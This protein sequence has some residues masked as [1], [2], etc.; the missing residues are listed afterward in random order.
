MPVL[1]LVIRILSA[2]RKA[3]LICLIPIVAGVSNCD[4]C[5]HV[6]GGIIFFEGSA[7]KNKVKGGPDFLKIF[8]CTPLPRCV[9]SWRV[10]REAAFSFCH[11][12]YSSACAIFK[13]RLLIL[14]K[15][16]PCPR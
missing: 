12:G 2:C 4:R 14:G 3:V 9:I 8:Y 5:Y 6:Y 10:D 11:L 13:C 16:R 15:L 1:F 7:P